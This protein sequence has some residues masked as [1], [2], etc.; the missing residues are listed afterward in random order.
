[1]PDP[2]AW[3]LMVATAT[4][5]S[6]LLGVAGVP[7]TLD[8]GNLLYLT[9]HTFRIDPGCTGVTWL[10]LFTIAVLLM[11]VTGKR[12]MQG[13]LVGL[14]AL[15]ILNFG[16]LVVV[17]LVSEHSPASFEFVHDRIMQ[18]GFVVATAALWAIWMWVSRND[19]KPG[20][21]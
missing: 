15:I 4:A 9:N 10:L 14:P 6:A 8:Q 12:K 18:G 11:P 21:E 19:W 20:W 13:L 7:C 5:T 17:A 2:A 3:A 16:R 1:M